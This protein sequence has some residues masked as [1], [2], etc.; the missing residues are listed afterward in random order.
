MIKQFINLKNNKPIEMKLL[1]TSILLLFHFTFFAQSNLVTGDYK[2]V[3]GKEND[4]L[5]KYNL[6]LNPDGTFLFHYYSFIKQGIPPEVNKYGKGKWTE[7]NNVV[8]FFSDKNL[9]LD[10]KYTIDFSKSKARF[11]TKSPRNKTDEII[12]TRLRFIESE[13]FWMKGIN[14]FKM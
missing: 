1:F 7:E 12:K 3:F 11:V 8:T 9:D 5:F 13:I 10:D 2:L 6:T 14:F 4:H